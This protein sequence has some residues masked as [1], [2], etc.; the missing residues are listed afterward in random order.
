LTAAQKDL[1]VA[2]QKVVD[3][4]SGNDREI[5]D[6]M[7]EM[8]SENDTSKFGADERNILNAAEDVSIIDS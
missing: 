1:S 2:I 8:R 4:T 7:A 5:G 3:L 6:A